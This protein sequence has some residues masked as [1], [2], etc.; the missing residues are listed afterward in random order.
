MLSSI[1]GPTNFGW[2]TKDHSTTKEVLN[3]LRSID[4]ALYEDVKKTIG[5]KQTFVYSYLAGCCV[6]ADTRGLSEEIQ[7]FIN[8]AVKPVVADCFTAIEASKNDLNDQALKSKLIDLLKRVQFY[9]KENK[10]QVTTEGKVFDALKEKDLL[11]FT[12][13]YT[14]Y[15]L[16]ESDARFQ[17]ARLEVEAKIG[18]EIAETLEACNH[19]AK[20]DE[21]GSASY[22]RKWHVETISPFDMPKDYDNI[23]KKHGEYVQA[24]PDPVKVKIRGITEGHPQS[25]RTFHAV[26]VE[27]E[28]ENLSA[29][30]K[31][32]G[33][34]EKTKFPPLMTLFSSSIV[35]TKTLVGHSIMEYADKTSSPNLQKLARNVKTYVSGSKSA[36]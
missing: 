4:M 28:I 10:F 34:P 5:E 15:K 21:L 12:G 31:F 16:R 7:T 18:N 26:G 3:E 2:F 25:G 27:V 20:T 30:R 23:V 35:P 1:T 36:T 33:L 24:N 8:Q 29:Y 22:D 9:P 6:L 19:K 11:T 13:K 17:G 32:C 14:L